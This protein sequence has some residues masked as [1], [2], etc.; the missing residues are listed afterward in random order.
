M[1]NVLWMRLS[2]PPG[3]RT[4]KSNSREISRWISNLFGENRLYASSEKSCKTWIRWKSSYVVTD[5]KAKYFEPWNGEWETDYKRTNFFEYQENVNATYINYNKQL[6]KKLGVQTGLR[7]ENTNYEG[8]QYGNAQKADSS[9]SKT[10]NG[11]FPTVHFSYA[12]NERNQFGVSFGRRIDR[13]AYQ[14]L[15]H[16]CFY[17]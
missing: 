1:I 8:H 4:T 15:N 14:D 9:F 11:I 13:P 7:F 2:H 5:S 12:A 3:Q 17:W 16:S 6:T 10:Y